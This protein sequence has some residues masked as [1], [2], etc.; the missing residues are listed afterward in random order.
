MRECFFWAMFVKDTNDSFSWILPYLLC[1]H[2]FFQYQNGT[3]H[4][5][6]FYSLYN[7][8]FPVADFGG[9]FKLTDCQSVKFKKFFLYRKQFG[10]FVMIRSMHADLLWF[11]KR[12]GFLINLVSPCKLPNSAEQLSFM[13]AL[14]SSK[15]KKF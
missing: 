7:L 2:S 15:N 11:L 13:K 4:C 5:R 9:Y 14:K 12:A 10:W 8:S 1:L 6:N 3:F